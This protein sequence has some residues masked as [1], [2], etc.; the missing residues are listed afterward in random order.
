M[1]PPRTEAPKAPSG[2]GY[3]EG[4]PLP[5]RLGGL[6][7]RLELPWKRILAYFGQGTLYFDLHVGGLSSSNSTC[8]WCHITYQVRITCTPLS[9]A[10][11]DTSGYIKWITEYVVYR[12][13]VTDSVVR[14]LLLVLVHSSRSTAMGV[15]NNSNNN[16]NNNNNT[17][18]YNASIVIH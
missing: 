17:K 2:V 6:G 14:Y 13:T 5:S 16:N 1:P 11:R 7:E 10:P 12:P 18:I 4:C 3:G 9:F 15:N 8:M